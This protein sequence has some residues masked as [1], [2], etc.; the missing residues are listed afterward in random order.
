MYIS[1]TGGSGS[2][3]NSPLGQKS[4]VPPAATPPSHWHRRQHGGTRTR[5][6]PRVRVCSVPCRRRRRT[7]QRRECRKYMHARALHSR[8]TTLRKVLNNVTK[9]FFPAVVATR[10]QGESYS[11]H[12]LQSRWFYKFEFQIARQIVHP[13]SILDIVYSVY[14]EIE[15]VSVYLKSILSNSFI[16]DCAWSCSI[17]IKA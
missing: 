10:G 5:A 12:N 11:R 13:F 8:G 9:L 15:N 6:R 17:R 1:R 3:V 16:F 14:S 7:V 4:N 2:I